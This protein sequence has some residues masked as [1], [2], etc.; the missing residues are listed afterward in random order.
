MSGCAHQPQLCSSADCRDYSCQSHDTC[1]SQPSAAFDLR[2][3]Q[4][5]QMLAQPPPT[6]PCLRS[7]LEA[8]ADSYSGFLPGIDWL[9]DPLGALIAKEAGA[10]APNPFLWRGGA[11]PPVAR[12][13]ILDFLHPG[14]VTAENINL[15]WSYLLML[16]KVPRPKVAALAVPLSSIPTPVARVKARRYGQHIWTELLKR[17]I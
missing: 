14:A 2:Y 6:P 9:A 16:K 3:M 10:V 1:A 4:A 7:G 5:A 15:R 11:F 12:R 13:L 17:D 8:S